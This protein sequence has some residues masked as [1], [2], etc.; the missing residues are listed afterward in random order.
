VVLKWAFRTLPKEE[1]QMLAAVPVVKQDPDIWHGVNLTYYG[2]LVALSCVISTAVALVLI[3]SVGIPGRVGLL[4]VAAI[5]GVCFP[6]SRMVARIVEKRPHTLTIAGSSFLGFLAAPGIVWLA[7]RVLEPCMG[8]S[9]PL[10]PVLAAVCVAYALGEGLGR[11]AC[12]S[13]GCCYGKPLKECHPLVQRALGRYGFVFWGKT[14]KIAYES[15]LEGEPVIPVQAITSVLFVAI[16]ALGM[17]LYFRGWYSEVLLVCI[18]ATQSWRIISETVRSD[19]RGEGSWSA[20]Q[21][22]AALAVLGGFLMY[23]ALPASVVQPAD[24]VRGLGT[25]W[26]PAVI[27]VLQLLLAVTFLWAGRSTV[28]ASTMTFRIR[29]REVR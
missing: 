7:D 4:I 10:A 22:L 21:G 23:G 16:S 19:Y 25:L 2:L 29:K 27:I 26:D 15:G 8:V 20:Y 12:I 28:T 1:W 9:L 3:G 14:K 18:T 11:L 6:A 17:M 24:L 5:L 13:F